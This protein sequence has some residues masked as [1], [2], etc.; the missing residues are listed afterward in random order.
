MPMMLF[1]NLEYITIQHQVTDF[2]QHFHETFCISLIHQGIELIDLD[3]QR[4]YSEK[5]SLS[6]TNPYE[7]HANPMVD[8][9]VQL[10]FDTIY[11]SK[12][13]MSYLY[14]GKDVTFTN[15]KINDN[16]ANQL[17]MQLKRAID[18]K[19]SRE[20]ENL[21]FQFT[22]AIAQ[23]TQSKR[24]GYTGINF[25]SLNNIKDFI[26]HNITEKFKLDELARIANHNKYG[27]AKKFRKSTGMSPMNYI[28][29]QKIFSSKK[30]ITHDTELTQLAYDYQFSD[31]A[32]F[33]KTFKRY[34]GVSPKE[35][36]KNIK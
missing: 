23:H 25:S 3:G 17:F 6:I 24:E 14:H 2:P 31:L 7:I 30:I 12:D 18:H 28:L 5:G 20:I 26:D 10:H 29:M 33:S 32:H 15:R 36:Q 11:I 4:I 1:D 9:D 13:L 27:F 34:I 22:A 21:L 35:F 8:A 16:C 19:A